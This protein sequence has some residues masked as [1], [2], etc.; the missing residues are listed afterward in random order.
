MVSGSRRVATPPTSARSSSTD[1]SACSPSGAASEAEAAIAVVVASDPMYQPTETEASP[2]VRTAFSEVR[3]RQLPDIART[4]YAIGEGVVRQE[5]LSVRRTP[6]PRAAPPDR[7]S[8]H[9]WA[10]GRPA[11]ARDWLCRPHRCGRGACL[12]PSR[13][14]SRGAKRLRRPRPRR[15]RS[16]IR[17][18]STPR[19]TRASRRLRRSGRKC[20]ACRYRSPIRPASGA[21]S[22]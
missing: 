16:R 5:G 8:R 21:S 22:T 18:R 17:R 13:S 1:R 20:R 4:R 2:R 12:R 9:G 6:V 7:R 19:K 3:Q 11:H 14:R 10:A 15:R